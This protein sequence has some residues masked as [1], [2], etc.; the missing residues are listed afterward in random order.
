MI[1]EDEKINEIIIE[2]SK[3]FAK[4]LIFGEDLTDINVENVD[5]KLEKLYKNYLHF[6]GDS[7]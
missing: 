4:Y 2:E 5:K 7:R 6:C 1:L 3:L